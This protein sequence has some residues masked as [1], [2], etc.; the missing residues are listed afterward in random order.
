MKGL[1]NKVGDK[2]GVTAKAKAPKDDVEV[3]PFLGASYGVDG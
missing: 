1:L 3:L 2:V